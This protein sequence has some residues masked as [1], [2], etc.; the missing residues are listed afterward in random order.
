MNILYLHNKS[1]IS[2][3]ERSL[4]NLWENLE[5]PAHNLF[6]A[7]P[8]EGDLTVE[9]H[10]LDLQ[11]FYLDVP[12]L[13]FSNIAIILKT[14]VRLVRYIL[15][16]KIQI[17]HS[18]TPRNNILSS[19]VGKILRVPVIW[20][21]RNLIF[22][23]EK[24]LSKK[25]FFLADKIICNSV[26]VAERF[27]IQKEL[28]VKLKVILNGVN[29][30]KFH[31]PENILLLKRKLGFGNKKI[32]GLLS[33]LNKRK[34]VEYFLDIASVLAKNREDVCFVVVGGDF[35]DDG[36]REIE[37]L[38]IKAKELGIEERITFTG[39]INNVTEY[40]MAFDICAH[41]T[42]KEACSRAILESMAVGK[43]VVAINEGGNP[44][45]VKEDVTG[46]LLAG[47]D[48]QGFVAKL[49][50]LL[51]D[52]EKCLNMGKKGREYCEK[53]FDVKHNA[54]QIQK[55]YNELV[56]CGNSWRMR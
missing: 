28:D 48:V 2:G 16:N 37:N 25:F 40:L 15:K 29:L 43:P 38:K 39:F 23:D 36:M 34:R 41:V 30:T 18:Y 27:G 32:I 1:Q 46:F 55:V 14:M 42:L 8:Y 44:E 26:A 47:D 52:D 10:K 11:V 50:L 31:A 51:D 9:A 20:H 56:P 19:C 12:A 35:S 22:E 5:H 13:K 45:L 54:L 3:G 6:L 33:N 49:Q 17:I 4:L 21:E 53:F 24:D 7:V